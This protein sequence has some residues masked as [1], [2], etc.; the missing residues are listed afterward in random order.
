MI[1]DV[2]KMSLN[3]VVFI[4]PFYPAP[5]CHYTHWKQTVFYLEDYLTVKYGEEL[6]GE[7]KMQPNPRNNV[8]YWNCVRTLVNL[9][10]SSA[11]PIKLIKLIRSRVPEMQCQFTISHS[12]LRAMQSDG[13]A[14]TNT[15][16]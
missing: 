10:D 3:K 6:N 8:S 15:A 12:Q 2:F 11:V 16:L 5:D 4:F 14:R 13:A 1:V 9:E 7:F